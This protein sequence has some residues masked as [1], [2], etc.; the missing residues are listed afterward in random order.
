MTTKVL[1]ANKKHGNILHDD[2][3]KETSARHDL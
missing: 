2:K 3:N 1:L